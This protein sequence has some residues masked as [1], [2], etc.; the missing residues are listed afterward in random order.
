[1]AGPKATYNSHSMHHASKTHVQLS[2]SC[3]QLRTAPA[4]FGLNLHT[5]DK[6]LKEVCSLNMAQW[7]TCLLHYD[8][9][10]RCSGLYTLKM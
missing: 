4:V 2:T 3:H 10:S 9:Q 8:Q 6:G 7:L 5:T 1:M